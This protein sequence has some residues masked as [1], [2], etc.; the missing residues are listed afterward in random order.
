LHEYSNWKRHLES[1]IDP[2]NLRFATVREARNVDRRFS[3]E[4]IT[5]QLRRIYQA[6]SNDEMLS[7]INTIQNAIEGL[8]NGTGTSLDLLKDMDQRQVDNEINHCAN[9]ELLLDAAVTP[10]SSSSPQSSAFSST[11]PPPTP[12][13]SKSKTKSLHSISI[14]KSS[15]NGNHRHSLSGALRNAGLAVASGIHS[16]GDKQHSFRRQNSNTDLASTL[17][18]D[19]PP[20]PL[21]PLPASHL[22]A[23]TSPSS[24]PPSND[25]FRWSMLSTNSIS[26]SNSNNHLNSN[27]NINNNSTSTGNK[28]LT[29]GQYTFSPSVNTKLIEDIRNEESNRFCADCGEKN[30]DWCSLNLGIFLC[31]GK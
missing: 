21:P 27:N 26:S 22:T 16:P 14:K 7:W 25:R 13:P 28:T 4:V 30:P 20:P 9:V 18:T 15:T 31:I 8:L 12:T 10:S 17:T 29:P 3:F 2:I 1:N 23:P 19:D 11:M 6:T 24:S 5:P